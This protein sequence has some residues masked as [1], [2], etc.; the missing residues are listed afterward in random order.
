M[1]LSK[2]KRA[3]IRKKTKNRCWYCGED[4]S[5]GRMTIDHVQPRSRGGARKCITNLVPACAACNEDKAD[6]TLDEYQRYCGVRFY[7][8]QWEQSS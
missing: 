6:M 5:G 8:Q 3:Q 2:A 1:I 4:L 7:G